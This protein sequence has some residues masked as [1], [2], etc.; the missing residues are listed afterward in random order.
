MLLIAHRGFAE[1]RDE[2]TL[3]AFTRAA[4]DPRIDGVEVDIR[5]SRDRSD[6][7]LR[8][9]PFRG[10]SEPTPPSLDDALDFASTRR[11][12]VLL[13]CKE[14]DDALFARVRA[15]VTKHAIADRVVLFGFKDVAEKFAWGRPRPFRF[16]VI[17]EYPWRIAETVARF[18]PDVVLM[19]WAGAWTRCAVK[20]YWSVRSLKRLAERHPGTQFVMG[21]AQS[22]ADIAWLRRRDALYAAT[23]DFTA[24]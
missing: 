22:E 14:Y 8:H 5:W 3:A 7:V 18:A 16:G 10:G 6:V 15:L 20:T 13:E 1:G 21:V 23:V 4:A 12:Q 24:P 19:G 11:W 17:E 9:D 2:N